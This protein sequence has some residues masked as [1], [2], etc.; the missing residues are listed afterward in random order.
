M[1]NPVKIMYKYI[2][3]NVLRYLTGAKITGIVYVTFQYIK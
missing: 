1:C 2:N 3:N